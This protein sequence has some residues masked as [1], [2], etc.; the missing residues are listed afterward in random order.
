MIDRSRRS[1]W[2]ERVNVRGALRPRLSGRVRAWPVLV[3][4]CLL[5]VPLAVAQ[6]EIGPGTRA[7]GGAAAMPAQESLP[8]GTARLPQAASAAAP[9]EASST[10]QFIQTALTLGVV[11]GLIL[12]AGSVV[13][14]LAR[15]KGGLIGELGAGGKAPAG[16]LEVLGR[17][18][19]S[20]GS[21]LVLLKLDRRVLL[22]CQTVGR[23]H[24]GPSMTTL[25]EITEPEEVASLLMKTR[26]DEG[27][28][29]AK[30]FQAMLSNEDAWPRVGARGENV[31]DS[32]LAANVEEP[33]LVEVPQVSVPRRSNERQLSAAMS[34]LRTRVDSLGGAR[35]PLAKG[36]R[37]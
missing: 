14:K 26:E 11:I 3:A 6:Q 15:S 28:S 18:P 33:L 19:V 35:Q 32:A 20:R 8:L 27:D 22:T 37:S 13:R 5:V 21:T 34:V 9:K 25:C 12:L 16:V 1:R 7:D 31:T 29:L 4:T 2:P 30:K 36:G 10:G 23:K 17:Y 24:S